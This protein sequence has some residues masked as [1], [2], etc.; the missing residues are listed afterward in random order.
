MRI[1]DWI[2][3]VCSSDLAF[4]CATDRDG[5]VIFVNSTVARR[6]ARSDGDVVGMTRAEILSAPDARRHMMIDRRIYDGLEEQL[7][8][9]E[10]LLGPEGTPLT[11]L[12]VKSALRNGDGSIAG[13]VTV[14]ID[15]SDRKEIE[16]AARRQ[17]AHLRVALNN[18][19]TSIKYRKTRVEDK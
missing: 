8:F 18:I 3:D 12:T 11:C 5:R 15:I 19:P 13:V 17:N 14:A 4:V 10:E 1:S 7:S 6:L 9:E 2:S 16:R